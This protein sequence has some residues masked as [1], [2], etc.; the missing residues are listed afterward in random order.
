M[1]EAITIEDVS[2]GVRLIRWNRPAKKNALTGA[3][4][5]AATAALTGADDDSQNIGAVVFAGGPGAFTA[6]NDLA[7]FFAAGTAPRASFSEMPALRFIRQLARTRTPMVA[8]VDGLAIGV[9]TTLTLHCDLVY[10][11]PQARFRMPFVELGVVPEAAA[12]HLLPRRI[13]LARA[14]ALLLLGEPF[15]GAAAVALGLANA[16][17]PSE[18]LEAH[19]LAQAARLAT[20]PRRAV[21]ATRA[22]MR[23]DAA[24]VEAAIEAEAQAFE[25]GLRDPETQGR[26]ARFLAGKA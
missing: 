3:M 1:S 15:D 13:G 25:A 4:Y 5:D 9:G 2:G 14:S 18:A 6:G 10:V 7:D 26:L 12:S 8:A 24:A 20:L 19:A 17:L 23:G 21:Q 16:E 11:G 22:L